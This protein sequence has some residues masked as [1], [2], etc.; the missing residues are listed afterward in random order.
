[1]R[2]KYLVFCLFYIC[3]VLFGNNFASVVF[4]A[5]SEERQEAFEETKKQAAAGDAEAQLDLG[6]FFYFGKTTYY[7]GEGIIPE[8]K[9]TYLSNAVAAFPYPQFYLKND[10]DM[11]DFTK[12]AIWFEAAASQ[13]NAEAEFF[14]GLMN[15][16]GEIEQSDARKVISWFEKSA[17]QGDVLAQYALGE[18]SNPN[19]FND[20]YNIDNSSKKSNYKKAFN[21]YMKAALQGYSWA[22]YRLGDMYFNGYG[23]KKNY[24]KAYA[25]FSTAVQNNIS[26]TYVNTK[27]DKVATKLSPKEIIAAEVLVEKYLEQTDNKTEEVKRKTYDEL[28]VDAD[29]GDPYAQYR[30]GWIYYEG[31]GVPTDLDKA[32]VWFEKSA[33]QGDPYAQYQ[34][35]EMYQFSDNISVD[36]EKAFTWYEK[37]AMQGNDYAQWRLGNMYYNG[38]SVPQDYIKAYAWFTASNIEKAKLG[39]DSITSDLSPKELEKATALADEYINKFRKK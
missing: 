3:L 30:I 27:K 21:W 16:R 38:D 9:E 7:Y 28:K 13:N 12:A 15:L 20:S 18:L 26:S 37:S 35:G 22:Q 29:N 31:Y 24:N 5:I 6:K 11:Q 19:S 33:A 1:M 25:W 17:A 8:L 4:A 36:L 32:L 34:L 23:V 39:I 2:K 14:L 10:D